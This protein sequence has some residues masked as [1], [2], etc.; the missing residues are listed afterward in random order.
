MQRPQR[1]TA[2]WLPYHGQVSLLSYRT[3]TTTS[4]GMALFT[5]GC[6][7]PCPSPHTSSLIKKMPSGLY[8]AQSYGGIFS[9]EVPSSQKTLACV[10]LT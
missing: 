4:P 8:I 5:M 2:D 10:K 1:G 6:L 7:T 9:A 3:R